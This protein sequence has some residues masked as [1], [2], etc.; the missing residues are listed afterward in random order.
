MGRPL[1]TASSIRKS[2]GGVQALVGVSFD[3][4]PG[5]VHALVGENGAGKSTLIS[6][7]TGAERADGGSLAIGDVPV[8]LAQFTPSR[9]RALGVAVIHQQPALFPDLTVAEN[10]ALTL[11]PGSTW[12]P[13]DWR[14]RRQRAADFLG[15]AGASFGPERLAGSLSMPEQQLVEIARAIGADARIVLMDEPTASLTDREVDHLFGVVARLKDEGA[16][17]LYISHRLDEVFALADR[18]TVLRDGATVVSGPRD[19]LSRREVVRQ[20]A[21]RELSSVSTRQTVTPGPVALELRGLSAYA[22][23]VRDVSLTVRRG[24]ILGIA[25]LVGSGRTALAETVFGLH[26]IDGGEVRIGD[27]PTRIGSP[28]DA[29]AHGI[30]YVPEDRRRHGVVLD[31]SIAANTS[32][33][34]LPSVSRRGLV[35][36]DAE[37]AL[38]ARFIAA[39]G[40]KAHDADLPVRTLSGGNQQKVVLAR[41]LATN[42]SVLMLDEPTQGVDVSA[43]AE[44]HAVMQAMVEQGLAILMIS[45]DLPEILEMSD[46]VA[47]MRDGTIA[48]TLSR[49]EATAESVLAIALAQSPAVAVG[50]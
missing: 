35:Q 13:I 30:A 47:V 48:A 25:G 42:P 15:R 44:I 20:M 26:R 31:M 4:R 3:L 32:M 17:M 21:G 12:Q 43:K 18:V 16:G 50:R 45:S 23:G 11:E 10:I 5:E 14:A 36:H 49:I 41:W 39:L 33:A 29:I 1:L 28:V 40:I 37:Q 46:R 19:A 27:T 38:A 7:V 8:D 6:I 2:Y 24:E 34:C 22:A 9:A